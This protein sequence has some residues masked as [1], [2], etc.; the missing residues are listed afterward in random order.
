MLALATRDGWLKPNTEKARN[1]PH[2][3]ESRGIWESAEPAVNG[4][5]E[6]LRGKAR[7]RASTKSRV[8]SGPSEIVEDQRKDELRAEATGM[9][10]AAYKLW[11]VALLG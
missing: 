6:P 8:R 1:G 4:G 2:G 3:A 7:E 5:L 9:N 11:P 10:D